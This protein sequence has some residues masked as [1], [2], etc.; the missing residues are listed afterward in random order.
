MSSYTDDVPFHMNS[1]FSSGTINLRDTILKVTNWIDQYMVGKPPA[2][3]TT[4]SDMSNTSTTIELTWNNPNQYKM[5]FSGNRVPYINKTIIQYKK[6]STAT[7]TTVA[8]PTEDG[9]NLD[10][11]YGQITIDSVDGVP[12]ANR[13][14]LST[15]GGSSGLIGDTDGQ[16]TYTAYEAIEADTQYDVRLYYNNNN[17]ETS[18]GEHFFAFP[19]STPKTKV[20][21]I[22]SEVTGVS[23]TPFTTSTNI[24]WTKPADHDSAVD[25]N[26]TTPL[27]RE[28][29]LSYNAVSTTS[30]TQDI[31][32][33]NTDI[34][35]TGSAI[36]NPS[37]SKNIGIIPAGT[38]Y[39]FSIRS[40]NRQNPNYSA[41][42]SDT[43]TT[44]N[45][46]AGSTTWSSLGGSLS[47]ATGITGLHLDGSSAGTVYQNNS[48]SNLKTSSAS[49]LRT[50]L[51]VADTSAKIGTI[52]AHAAGPNQ[53]SYIISS[54]I[55]GFDQPVINSGSQIISSDSAI[56][57]QIT[58][59]ADQYNDIYREGFWKK[60]TAFAG[61]KDKSKFPASTDSYN[62][63]YSY[64]YASTDTVNYTA[65]NTFYVDGLDGTKPSIVDGSLC[66]TGVTRGG[67]GSIQ[68]VSGV[69]TFASGDT[70]FYKLMIDDLAHYFLSSTGLHYSVNFLDT[71]TSATQVGKANISGSHPYYDKDN[72]NL[73]VTST[74]KHNGDG[75]VLNAE[76]GTIQFN[77]FSKQITTTDSYFTNNQGIVATP[78][79]ILGYGTTDTSYNVW[80]DDGQDQGALRIDQKSLTLISTLG[81]SHV[82]LNTDTVTS[83]LTDS[84]ITT[85]SI[86]HSVSLPSNELLIYN[87]LFNSAGGDGFLNY[88]TGYY[89]NGATG[90][91]Y[92]SASTDGYRYAVFKYT[93][94]AEISTFTLTLNDITT[95]QITSFDD[96]NHTLYFHKDGDEFWH[97]AAAIVNGSGEYVQGALTDSGEHSSTTRYCTTQAST[98]TTMH[99]RIGI[100]NN[101]SAKF[102]SISIS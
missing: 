56:Y 5:G 72:N 89:L 14:V 42:V 74:T 91:N 100:K 87:G 71:I 51:T 78:H 28:Y 41:S 65:T 12:P 82:R 60:I 8:W 3:Q 20:A 44:S 34:T 75:L 46:S 92:S 9:I 97:N 69:P 80:N 47:G 23:T 31:N 15:E 53:L 86:D 68:Y 64:Q 16:K 90:P 84:T 101:S 76:P 77:T 50:N 17:S 26:Q 70:I 39:N 19:G 52:S 38:T 102:S 61:I 21:G 37:T 95:D 83:N 18:R 40:K 33:I 25:G 11:G 27:I 10:D 22:P 67:S 4:L 32:N 63:H 45:P 81:N 59:D 7:G 58:T 1:D 43:F 66:M 24:N 48:L 57:L 79:N 62:L 55:G 73:K 13:L 6:N 35:I 98:A 36:A 93:I 85:T 99:V 49:N 2:P 94:A 96:A 30:A 54:D 88:S 29:V